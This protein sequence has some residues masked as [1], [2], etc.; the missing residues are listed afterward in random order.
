[1][2][3]ARVLISAFAIFG[4]SAIGHTFGTGVIN[5]QNGH[6]LFFIAV[7]TISALALNQTLH[8]P[9]LALVITIAQVGT[10]IFFAETGSNDLKMALSHLIS[11]FAAYQIISRLDSFLT[12]VI[13]FLSSKF[14]FI[15]TI[16]RAR[17]LKAVNFYALILTFRSSNFSKSNLL[18]APPVVLAN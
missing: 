5:Y 12:A 16:F 1:M 6:Y 13:L 4:C 3:L 11:G 15:F 17:T 18:R 10:H 9:K 8:G 7:L 14:A 2:K